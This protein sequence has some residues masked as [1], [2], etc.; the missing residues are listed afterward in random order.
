[1]MNERMQR[2]SEKDGDIKWEKNIDEANIHTYSHG[3]SHT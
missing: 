3:F 2:R 1:M